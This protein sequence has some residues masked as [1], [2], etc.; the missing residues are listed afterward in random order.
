MSSVH[1]SYLGLSEE[2]TYATAVAPARFLELVS[3]GMAGK[4]DR[5]DSEAFRSGQRVAHRDRFQPNPKGAEGDLNLEVLD[6]SFG[7]LF[8]HMLG[9]VSSGA[10]SG[11]FTTHTASQG[12]LRGKSLTVQVGRVDN[13]GT[14]YPFTYDGCKVKDWELSNAVD[15]ILKLKVNLDSAKENIG[16]GAGAYA[17][18][19]PSYGTTNQLLTFVGGTVAIG[20][21]EFAVSDVSLKGDNSLKT[22]RYFVRTTAGKKEP[23]EEGLRKYTFDLKGEFEGLTHAN[24][25]A[26]VAATG[27]YATLS[28]TWNSPQGGQLAVTIAVARFDEGPV[29][30]DGAKIIEQGLKGIVLWDGAASP[31]S[32]AYKSKDVAP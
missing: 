26:S 3:E 24:R 29:N 32:I 17:L 14:A 13:T 5:I 15:G 18:A 30:F 21:V 25:V 2:S 20:G 28:A 6:G 16:A 22:D 31:V 19:T 1:D 10:P 9:T 8:K 23:L 12:D 27:A 4:Y 7:L 11:G